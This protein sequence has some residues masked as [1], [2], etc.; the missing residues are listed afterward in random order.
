MATEYSI[1]FP[2]FHR[3]DLVLTFFSS[4]DRERADMGMCASW[5]KMYSVEGSFCSGVIDQACALFGFVLLRGVPGVVVVVGDV[6]ALSDMSKVT[7]RYMVEWTLA[8]Q[9]LYNVKKYRISV[10]FL[11]SGHEIGRPDLRNSAG[12]KTGAGFWITNE[13]PETFWCRAHILWADRVRSDVAPSMLL[14]IFCR[15]VIIFD[16]SFVSG[17][18]DQ[19]YWLIMI[20]KIEHRKVI[21]FMD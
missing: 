8:N 6:F 11:R 17:V 18:R 10:L 12:R 16:F 2:A 3:P 9:F 15:S 1:Q 21:K 14:G 4:A 20:S 7:R 13:V 19:E 5:R